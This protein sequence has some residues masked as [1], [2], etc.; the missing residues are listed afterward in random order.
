MEGEFNS[1]SGEYDSICCGATE[2]VPHNYWACVQACAQ[3]PQLEV[4]C[5]KRSRMMQQRSSM[6]QLRLGTAK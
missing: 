2:A 3:V 4:P 5:N 1:W 6:P